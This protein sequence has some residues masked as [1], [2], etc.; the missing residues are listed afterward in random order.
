MFGLG[1]VFVEVLKDVAFRLAPF[2][3]VEAHQMI[4]EIRSRS[5]LDG[6]RG[7]PGADVDALATILVRLSEFAYARRD[8][9][10]EIDINP[11]SAGPDGAVALDA[12]IT[13]G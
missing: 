4:N 1:G 12:L 10:A 7:Q 6:V 11:L 13:R 8:H 5:V 3:A 9:I 2:D